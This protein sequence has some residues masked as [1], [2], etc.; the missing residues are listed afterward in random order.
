MGTS[1][2]PDVPNHLNA[3]IRILK[4]R[5]LNRNLSICRPFDFLA[6][7]SVLYQIFLAA[8]GSWVKTTSFQFSFD[9]TFWSQAEKFLVQYALCF[10]RSISYS[11]PILGIPPTLFRL[12]VSIKQIYQDP[13]RHDRQL[14]DQSRIMLGKWEMAAS[15]DQDLDSQSRWNASSRHSV[16]C[17]EVTY[18]YICVGSLLVEKLLQDGSSSELP[19]PVPRDKWQVSKALQ[20]L[21]NRHNE[22]DWARYYIGTWPVYTLGFSIC[23][24]EDIEIVRSDIRRRWEITRFAHTLHFSKDL[25]SVWSSRGFIAAI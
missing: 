21:Q 16:Y 18:L 5:L 8:T 12:F 17:K 13:S 22:D 6:V 10:S 4:L 15:R 14:L 20:I 23:A 1:S 3:A 19:Q 7:E 2:C 24:S 9:A 11:S 25:E